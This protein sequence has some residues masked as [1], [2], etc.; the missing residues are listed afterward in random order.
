MTGVGG[1]KWYFGIFRFWPNPADIRL[2]TLRRTAQARRMAKH[3]VQ[4]AARVL[5]ALADE[6]QA[7]DSKWLPLVRARARVA[8]A[9]RGTRGAPRAASPMQRGWG[10][11]TMASAR[12]YRQEPE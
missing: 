2:V 6:L 12:E 1:S 11:L 10:V 7:A 4:G 3:G 8:T 9:A 5:R